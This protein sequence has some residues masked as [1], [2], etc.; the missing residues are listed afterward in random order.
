MDTGDPPR[1]TVLATAYAAHP[2]IAAVY[3]RKSA[4]DGPALEL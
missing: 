3:A 4:A 1:A 2:M